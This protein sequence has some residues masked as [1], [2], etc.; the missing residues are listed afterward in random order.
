[1]VSISFNHALVFIT[2]T[3]KIFYFQGIRINGKITKYIT[4]NA[5]YNTKNIE[6]S[7]VH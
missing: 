6:A 4:E 1:M 3:N 2:S 5:Y 7:N